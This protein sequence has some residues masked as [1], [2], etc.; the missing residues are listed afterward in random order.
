MLQ[1][2]VVR[3]QA[4]H[5]QLEAAQLRRQLNRRRRQLL[6]RLQ[7]KSCALLGST[8]L[9]RYFVTTLISAQ[10]RSR[11]LDALK[12]MVVLVRQEILDVL[13]VGR[14]IEFVVESCRS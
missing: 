14:L 10:L 13:V 1:L 4:F 7:P 2:L 11:V 3:L 9:H 8:H 5:L 6:Q 12:A